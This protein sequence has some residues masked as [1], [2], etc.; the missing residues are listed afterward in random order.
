MRAFGSVFHDNVSGGTIEF[1][2]S[3][4]GHGGK[5]HLDTLPE[6][7]TI[8]SS[9]PRH[10][11]PRSTTRPHTAFMTEKSLPPLLP[12]VLGS[13]HPNAQV[14]RPRVAFG[15]RRVRLSAA[16][17]SSRIS[18]ARH[19]SSLG[20]EFGPTNLPTRR[21]SSM[22]CFAHLAM[23]PIQPNSVSHSFSLCFFLPALLCPGLCSFI[24]TIPFA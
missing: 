19:R 3:G 9:K 12:E 21:S 15:S 11:G 1:P 5:H 22:N 18:C 23:L 13:N 2:Y 4:A 8:A 17:L 10:D 20:A 16:C 7:M 14:S 24:R 6:R